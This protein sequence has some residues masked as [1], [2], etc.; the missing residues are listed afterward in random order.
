MLIAQAINSRRR[1]RNWC[2][3]SA[4]WPRMIAQAITRDMARQT[5]GTWLDRQ[6]WRR[7]LHVQLIAQPIGA[8]GTRTFRACTLAR[9]RSSDRT[10]RHAV[11]ALRHQQ[12]DRSSDKSTVSTASYRAPVWL[13]RDL[14]G[15]RSPALAT[16][17]HSS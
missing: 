9:D 3:V 6:E 17:D 7:R 2:R 1:R 12:F 15:Q 8:R 13:A 14:R 16:S 4:A 11:P 10:S 5:L